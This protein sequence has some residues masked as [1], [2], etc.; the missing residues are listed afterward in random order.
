MPNVTTDPLATQAFAS[1]AE[2]QAWLI[3]NH[4][5]SPGLWLKLAKKSSGIESVTYAQALDVA[6]CYG[7]IDSQ[8]NKFDEQYWLQRFGPR[9]ARSKWSM[10]NRQK[11]AVLIELGAMQPAGLREIEQAKADG[12]WDAAYPSQSTASVPDD[13]QLAL[14]KNTVAAKHFAAL[15]RSERYAILFRIHDAKKPETRTR[16]IEK[17]VDLLSKGNGEKISLWKSAS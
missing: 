13:L 15:T 5:A 17:Y 16:R 6:L 3:S 8:K 2:W 9:K 12:R 10:V 11:V 7:W 1:T 14:D 4:T